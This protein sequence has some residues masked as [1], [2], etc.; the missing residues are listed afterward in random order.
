MLEIL[1]LIKIRQKQFQQVNISTMPDEQVDSSVNNG[2]MV[3]IT[4]NGA[5]G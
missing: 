5:L 1:T 2:T 3:P 4:A